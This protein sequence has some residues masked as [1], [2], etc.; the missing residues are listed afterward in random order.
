ALSY[1]QERIGS[2]APGG[3][4]DDVNVRA[5]QLGAAYD[6][7]AVKVHA[8]CGQTRHGVFGAGIGNLD[9]N[10]SL[11]VGSTLDALKYNAYLVGLSAPVGAGSIMASWQ[12]AD[13]RSNPDAAP[14]AELDKM[15]IYSLG[16]TY[17]LSKRTNMYVFGS[18]AKDANF[19]DG[20]KATYAGVGLRH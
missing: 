9:S 1:E 7:E 19:I 12:M 5:W 16:Y 3:F 15:N 18:Y 8:A 11:S 4:G 13:P 6:F 14:N 2:A 10:A 17:N 20:V